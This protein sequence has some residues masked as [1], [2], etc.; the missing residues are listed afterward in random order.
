MNNL[1]LYGIGNAKYQYRVLRYYWVYDENTD[2]A[3]IKRIARMMQV[4]NPSIEHVY[5]ISNRR[6]LKRDFVESIK[7]NS[8]ESCAI[9]KDIL[10]REG[11]KIFYK[12]LVA[13][14]LS[15]DVAITLTV[16]MIH[17]IAQIVLEKKSEEQDEAE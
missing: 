6:G 3:E 2:I 13:S 4:V 5:L 14:G 15:E 11:I 8:I 9:F 7:R 16:K 12:A 17:E 10:E 1:I